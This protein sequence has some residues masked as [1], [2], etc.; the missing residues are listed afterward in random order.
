MYMVGKNTFFALESIGYLSN[1]SDNIFKHFFRRK[2]QKPSFS[3][4]LLS[5]VLFIV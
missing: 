4:N 2:S 1:V 5:D 3:R